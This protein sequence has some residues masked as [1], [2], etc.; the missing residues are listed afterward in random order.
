MDRELQ[1]MPAGKSK[2]VDHQMIVGTIEAHCIFEAIR[3][4]PFAKYLMKSTFSGPHEVMVTI[5]KLR[6]FY[7]HTIAP[8]RSAPWPKDT[9]C[10]E[11]QKIK[12]IIM[13]RLL[14]GRSMKSEGKFVTPMLPIILLWTLLLSHCLHLL[15]TDLWNDT[16]TAKQHITQSTAVCQPP[17]LQ[18]HHPCN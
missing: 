5:F 17:L 8:I 13:C 14:W 3:D 6:A 16:M 18:W 1:I 2:K 9:N 4:L 11:H 12:H 10:N 7:G 15:V